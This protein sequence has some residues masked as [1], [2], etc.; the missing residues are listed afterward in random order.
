[1]QITKS[2]FKQIKRELE[3]A[4]DGLDEYA[5][6]LQDTWVCSRHLEKIYEILEKYEEE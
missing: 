2:D 3:K 6:T 4:E 5:R 1:M